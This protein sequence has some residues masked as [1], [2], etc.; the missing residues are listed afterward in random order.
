MLRRLWLRLSGFSR[1]RA[2][3]LE[4]TSVSDQHSSS[5]VSLSCRPPAR[6]PTGRGGRSGSRKHTFTLGS[7]FVWG[8][9]HLSPRPLTDGWP[10]AGD[11]V[12]EVEGVLI[13]GSRV[14]GDGAQILHGEASQAARQ[15]TLAL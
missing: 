14:V 1:G 2:G 6:Y 11:L 4:A 8:G 15:G 13:A 12:L 7:V 10:P 9:Q 3:G 5:L